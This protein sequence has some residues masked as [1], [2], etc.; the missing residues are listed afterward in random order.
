MVPGHLV[1]TDN[2]G[3]DAGVSTSKRWGKDANTWW[4]FMN[5]HRASHR[6]HTKKNVLIALWYN[7]HNEER[8]NNLVSTFRSLNYVLNNF[9]T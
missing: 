9:P 3:K 5:I 8:G 6:E 2:G 1:T 4:A 7:Y